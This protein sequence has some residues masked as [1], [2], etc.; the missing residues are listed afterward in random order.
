[1]S[2]ALSDVVVVDLTRILAGPWATQVLAD[3]G[4]TVWKIERPELGDDTRRWGPPFVTTKAKQGGLRDDTVQQQSAYFL[5]A[6][7]GKRSVTLDIQDHEQRARLIELIAQA[8]ILVENYKVGNLAKY[9]LDYQSLVKV[10]PRLI[11]CSIT[12]FGQTGPNAEKP[13]YDAMIQAM[14]GLMS[15]TGEAEQSG[16]QPQK[17]GIAVT[18]IMTG[19]YAVSAILAALHYRHQ[20]GVG[21]HIDLSLFDTQVAMLANQASSYLVS[22]QVPERLG[23][24]HP[25][26]VPYQAFAT[27]DDY[28]YLAVGND[29]QFAR[30]C[31]VLE[32]SELTADSRYA[33]NAMRVKFRNQ[34]VEQLAKRFIQQPRDYWLARLEE[35]GVP[36]APINNL[37]HVFELEQVAARELR[38]TM[39]DR[40]FGTL[41]L[42]AN[43]VKFSLTP[44]QYQQTPPKLG[45]HNHQFAQW[46]E[47]RDD[48]LST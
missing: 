44:N 38:L 16:G 43:P 48:K 8:D 27:A 28:L 39:A 14:G 18:D 12:G 40:D 31:Q 4:A 25:S 42:V 30:C 13:G 34:L 36:V 29:Q 15:I 2:G 23:T 33:T 47:I 46:L 1:M 22:K 35:V 6:N 5:A 24:A 7:R 45:E 20:S 26:I 19:M 41:D 32:L 17:V 37:E 9:G 21:Q 10:N 3:Y 11:Y